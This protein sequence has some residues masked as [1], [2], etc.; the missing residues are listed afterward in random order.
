MPLPPARHPPQV[1]C[2]LAVAHGV[3]PQ[4]GQGQGSSWDWAAFL[5]T[6]AGLLPYAFEKSDAQ[7][8]WGGENVFAAAMGGR[9]LRLTAETVMGSSCMGYGGFGGG[10]DEDEEGE[11]AEELYDVVRYRLGELLA[12]AGH[13]S[14]GSE[15]AALFADVGG[16]APW[17]Q[18]VRSLKI[19]G[20]QYY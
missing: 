1:F 13:G 7:E 10:E 18:L 3:V 6:A 14:E 15:A 2:K 8:K 4:G 19:S 16:A 17:R 11:E 20:P 5:R 12:A 9:S